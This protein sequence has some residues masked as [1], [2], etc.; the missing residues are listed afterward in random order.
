[1]FS[2][3]ITTYVHATSFL[4]Q[5]GIVVIV[6]CKGGLCCYA[7]AFHLGENLYYNVAIA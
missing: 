1:M 2:Y 6:A 5:L 3:N 7:C 4:T